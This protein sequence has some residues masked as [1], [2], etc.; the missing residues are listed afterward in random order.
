MQRRR[1]PAGGL[2]KKERN[3]LRLRELAVGRGTTFVG[4]GMALAVRP[5][6]RARVT[7]TRRPLRALKV[8]LR[9]TS[10]PRYM[11]WSM[12]R[13]FLPAAC[14]LSPLHYTTPFHWHRQSLFRYMSGSPCSLHKLQRKPRA[15]ANARQ[16]V[17][18]IKKR[19]VPLKTLFRTMQRHMNIKNI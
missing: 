17:L 3:T 12:D 4:F 5:S 18:F 8:T 19:P 13:V 16:N 9:R 15:R 11:L 7:I 14:Q 2:G 6:E 1:E 10:V